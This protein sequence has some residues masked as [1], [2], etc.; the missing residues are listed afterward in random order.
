MAFLIPGLISHNGGQK[1]CYFFVQKITIGILHKNIVFCSHNLVKP[2]RTEKRPTVLSSL[3][4]RLTI[5]ITFLEIYFLT[6]FRNFIRG[7]I[8]FFW[9]LDFGKNYTFFSGFL[10]VV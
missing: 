2:R 3:Q 4:S 1:N 8:C 7:Y 6:H 9:D 10:V 5:A